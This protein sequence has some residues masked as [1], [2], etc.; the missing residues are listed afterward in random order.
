MPT[1]NGPGEMGRKEPYAPPSASG[2]E[3]YATDLCRGAEDINESG[4]KGGYSSI[5]DETAGTSP[6]EKLPSA[7]TLGQY[8]SFHD[9]KNRP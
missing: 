9:G 7:E 3:G 8:G 2:T 5:P 4:L 1:G 6:A